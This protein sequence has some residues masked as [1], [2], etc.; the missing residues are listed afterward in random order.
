MN[1]FCTRSI[2]EHLRLTPP[3]A[4]QQ[5]IRPFVMA[6]IPMII[7]VKQDLRFLEALELQQTLKKRR[8]HFELQNPLPSAARTTYIQN[9]KST[10]GVESRESMEPKSCCQV[11]GCVGMLRRK[12]RMES[13]KHLGKRT[14]RIFRFT[15]RAHHFLFP[16]FLLI[17]TMRYAVQSIDFLKQLDP[18]LFLPGSPL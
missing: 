13:L 15:Y 4:N 2:H 17:L 6:F 10:A 3:N 8:D 12:L 9:P 1:F 7:W 18:K 11:F 14:C 16:C 5:E